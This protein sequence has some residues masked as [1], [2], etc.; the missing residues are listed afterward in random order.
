MAQQAV[1]L[2]RGEEFFDERRPIY[3]NRVEES[4]KLSLH[5]HD[6]Y[7]ICYVGE[8]AGFHYIGDRCFPVRQGDVTFLPIG[9]P[10]VFRPQSPA[11]RHKLIVYNCL[12]PESVFHFARAQLPAADAELL[13]AHAD[14]DNYVRGREERDEFGRLFALLHEAFQARRP[15]WQLLLHGGA[16][17]LTGLLLGLARQSCAAATPPVRSETAEQALRLLERDF[18]GALTAASVAAAVGVSERQLGRLLR[19]RAGM[20]F[21]E[22]LQHMRIREACRLLAST[23]FKVSD[24]AARVG[25]QDMK[26]FNRL[27]KQKTGVTPRQYRRS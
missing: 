21:L 4:F 18:A 25:Y 15:G 1:M 2:S 14:G 24:I 3:V 13:P 12:F 19:A 26:Y 10:H 17:Q 22:L 11:S 5:T 20:S 27:F 16:L 8:G 7:E 9:I 23:P 6:F